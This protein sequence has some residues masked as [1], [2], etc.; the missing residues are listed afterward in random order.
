[1]ARTPRVRAVV[2]SY[3]AA[4]LTID[5]LEHLLDTDWPAGALEVVLVDNASSDSVA[6]RV[7]RELPFV[8]V[9]Q[10]PVNRGF[11][12]GCNLALRDLEG[13]DHVALVN[14]DVT[15][16]PTWLAP[17]VG[18][19]EAEPS[20]GAACPKILLRSRFRE[21]EIASRP[22]RRRRGDRRD[23]GVRV[24]GVRVA[25]R[26]A[27][28]RTRFAS[29]TWG[30][31]ADPL[32]REQRW[33]AA[34]AELLVPVPD[35]DTA[36]ST[37]ELRLEALGPTAVSA[38]SAGAT[39]EITV[40][41]DPAWYAV[42]FAGEPFDVVN[43]VGTVLV[44]DGY[45]ADRGYLERDTGQ[46]EEEEDVFAWCGA[47][48]LLRADYLRDVGLF[49]ER[50]FLYYEDLELAWRGIEH[51]WRHRYVPGSVVRHVHSATASSRRTRTAYYNERNHLL[52][53]ARHASAS[54]VI[55]ALAHFVRVSLSYG[56]RDVLGPLARSERPSIAA[57]GPRLR[58]LAGFVVSAPPILRGRRTHRA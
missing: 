50:L 42:P 24:S 6:D 57:L 47:A 44:A 53:L 33:T 11:A 16:H 18:V 2:V 31:E 17:L 23:L 35:G 40:E 12:G 15:V 7:R 41:R 55:A 3:D 54:D 22:V 48:A 38:R 58:A 1:M 19:L 29:G 13:V 27:W 37:C 5:C 14:N 20:V 21:V 32:G 8:R 25:G 26:D 10:S 39:A 43:N 49:D 56:A 4:D 52:V 30:P 34:T 28:R 9:I 45:G 51:G 46:Y 36:P